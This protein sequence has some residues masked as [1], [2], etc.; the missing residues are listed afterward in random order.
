M[1][2]E[3]NKLEISNLEDELIQKDLIIDYFMIIGLDE[4]YYTKEHLSQLKSLK[5]VHPSIISKFPSDRKKYP[6][7]ENTI[8]K[9]VIRNIF[10]LR[11]I[12]FIK[13]PTLQ[14]ECSSEDSIFKEY[15]I[16]SEERPKNIFH[17]FSVTNQ[18]QGKI[19]EAFK[20]FACLLVFE[21]VT[22]ITA[23]NTWKKKIFIAKALV[24]T[25]IYPYYS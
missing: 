18:S 14:D 4:N 13:D 1:V 20:H 25:S 9:I 12:D 23:K 22:K 11:E 10:P 15:I 2:E 5:K 24:I 6:F 21:D 7:N 17:I 16:E 19:Y 3:I 8:N